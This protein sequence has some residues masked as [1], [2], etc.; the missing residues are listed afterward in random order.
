M[1]KLSCFLLALIL[2]GLVIAQQYVPD[3]KI[4]AEVNEQVWKPFKKSYE[5]RDWKVFNDLH[6]DDVLRIH[7]WGGIQAGKAYKDQIE[8]SYQRPTRSTKVFDLWFEHRIYSENVGYEVGYYR[9]I[10]EEPGKSQIISVGRFHILL[11]KVEGVWKIAQ[12]WD[13][14]VING[15]KVT[16]D[17][18]SKG[19]PIEF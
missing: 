5:D 8:K 12:D 2:S 19:T 17:D 4:E 9:V 18:F 15:E 1:K 13:T 7:T 10:Y 16:A 11:R 6:T 14:S 3:P